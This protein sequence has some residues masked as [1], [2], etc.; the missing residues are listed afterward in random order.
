MDFVSLNILAKELCRR[1]RVMYDHTEGGNG[2]QK[3]MCGA[4]PGSA[5]MGRPVEETGEPFTLTHGDALPLQDYFTA[6]DQHFGSRIR[7]RDAHVAL[8]KRCHQ[9]RVIQKRL[10]LRYKDKNPSP[11]NQLDVLLRDT[12]MEVHA[13]YGWWAVC[14]GRWAMGGV[15]C[16][17]LKRRLVHLPSSAVCGMLT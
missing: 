11:L 16:A 9:H 4:P 17:N 5:I 8:E 12:H 7:Q 14:C 15:R 10:L 13:Y 2:A 1:L 3:A 6:V